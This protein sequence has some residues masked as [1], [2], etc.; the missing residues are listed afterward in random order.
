VGEERGSEG[1]RLANTIAPGSDYLVNGEPT[2]NRLATATRG[3]YR[4]RLCATGRAAH[5][6][7]PELGVSAI[8]KLVDAIVA[9]RHASWPSDA[10]LGETHYTIGVIKGGVAPNVVPPDA[11]AEIMFRTIGDHR[12]LQDLLAHAVRDRATVEYVMS[13]PPVSLATVP[14]VPTAS[15]N[16]TTDIPFLDRW[17]APLL[18]GPG[19]VTL[20]H[21][22]DEYVV[23]TDLEEAVD[24]YVFVAR[25]LLERPPAPAA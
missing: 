23:V 25:H 7:Q 19:S 12:V 5:S 14:G 8:E 10:V 11:E 6:S 17:G 1:A 20:A 3:I 2:D 21:T 24:R 16:F 13:V 18:L 22:A 9:M 15:F 4:A